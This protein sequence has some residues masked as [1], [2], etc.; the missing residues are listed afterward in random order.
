MKLDEIKKMLRYLGL[1]LH[2]RTLRRKVDKY[3]IYVQRNDWNGMREF[4]AENVKELGVCLALEHIGMR[5]E[6]IESLMKG[7]L[8]KSIV[9]GRLENDTQINTLLQ[10]WVTCE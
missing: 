2:D 3:L 4:S 10:A 9:L 8:P 6:E 1:D 5:K 7:Y